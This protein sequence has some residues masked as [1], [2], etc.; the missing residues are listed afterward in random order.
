MAGPNLKNSVVYDV[1]TTTKTLTDN[2]SVLIKYHSTAR[3]ILVAESQGGAINEDLYIIRNGDR[4]GY[5]PNYDFENVE[6]N[7]FRFSAE[8]EYGNVGTA[9]VTAP[10]INYVRLTCNM[11]NNKP[12]ADGNMTLSCSGNYFNG[13]FGEVN[14]SLT[15]SY[16]YTGS[17][18]SRGSG[19]MSVTTKSNNSY[20]ASE[21]IRGLDYQTTYSFTIT[22]TDKLESVTSSQNGVT[23][24]PTFH[25]GKNDFTFEVP[26]TFN[27]TGITRVKGDLQLKGDA[28]YG[29]TLY[30]GDKGYCYIKEAEDDDLT[31]HADKTIDLSAANV[32]VNGSPIS[33]SDSGATSDTWIPYLGSASAVLGYD[34]REGWYQKV[35][36]VVTIG[37]NLKAEV[38]SGYEDTELYI[39][40][41]PFTPSV[42]AFG[43]GVAF[44]I[45]TKDDY[46]FEGWCIDTDGH[47]TARLGACGKA[48]DGDLKISSHSFYP[49]LGGNV[50]LAGTI[51]YMTD[52]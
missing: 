8:D 7:V 47:I 21:E 18:G 45:Y 1:N 23:S 41:V 4:T 13:S 39:Y 5:A 42:N 50:T 43:G 28:N 22:A 37:W 19:T 51:C 2:D 38:N 9:T 15:V 32:T 25:W 36:N 29:N 40:N 46:I 35:G 24:L 20:D 34:V 14:N 11:A 26:V 31:I 16:S 12:D 17:D 30:F 48:S 49:E 6:S 27:S 33:G 52:E 10:M 44:N 3:A